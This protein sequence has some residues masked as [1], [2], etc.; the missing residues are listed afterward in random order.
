MTRSKGFTLIE[1]MVVLAILAI[2]AF[3]AVPSF[4]TL[5]RD[6]RVE[7]QAEELNALLQYARS[8]AVIRKIDTFV[9]ITPATGEISVRPTSEN[10]TEILRTSTVDVNTVSLDVSNTTVGYRFN[11]T[12]TVPGFEALVCSNG[13]VESGRLLTVTGGG[14]TTLHNKGKKAD[15]SDLGSCSL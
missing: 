3:I 5:I 11:G 1:L 15:G 4:T 13:N 2:V 10:N 14:T 9:T 7:A 12:T 6:N 8:E